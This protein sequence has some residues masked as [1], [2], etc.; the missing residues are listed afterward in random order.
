MSFI[1]NRLNKIKPSSTIAVSQKARDLKAAGRDVIAL[2]AGEPDFD[3]PSH[4]IEV[5]KQAL[6]NGMTRY[7]PI[8]GTPELQDAV[9]QKFKRDNISSLSI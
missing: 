2:G 4:I 1:S 7:T 3:T 9:I 5:A 6:D 8:N